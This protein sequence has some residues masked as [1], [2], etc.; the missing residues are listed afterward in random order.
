M[1]V[2]RCRYCGEIYVPKEGAVRSYY[3][4][5]AHKH[6]AYRERERQRKR[7]QAFKKSFKPLPKP[8]WGR[9]LIN[10]L[11]RENCIFTLMHYVEPE[12]QERVLRE[13]DKLLSLHV[14]GTTVIP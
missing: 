12:Y 4:K 14:R 6:A 3:C 10:Y 8:E 1:V 2:L 5:P 9:G 11:L 13:V 7:I